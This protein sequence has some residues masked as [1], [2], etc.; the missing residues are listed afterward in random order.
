MAV[1]RTP[2]F[3]HGICEQCLVGE[4]I[5]RVPEGR[6]CRRCKEL[7][8]PALAFA[9]FLGQQEK[10]FQRTERVVFFG[11][12]G[13][14][15]KSVCIQAKFGQQLDSEHKRWK[16]N[17]NH[18]SKAW[19]VYFRRTSPD[20][21]QA[22]QRSFEFFPVIDPS[23]KFNENKHL[24]TLPSCGGAVFEYAQME[25]VNDRYKYKSREWSYIGVDEGSEFEEVMIE[26]AETRLRTADPYL[27]PYLQ[28]VVGSNPDGPHML[29][30][31]DRFIEP[32][33]PETVMSVETKLRDGRMIEYRQVYIP[34]RLDDNP[35][36]MESGTYEASLMNKRPEIRR[37]ILEGDW[38]I[39]AGAFLGSIWDESMHVVEDHDIPPGA[40]IFRAG[41]WGINNP[42]SIGWWY[43]DADGGMTMFDH[44][45][46]VGLTVDKVCEK[47]KVIEARWGL[48]DEETNTSGLNFARNP[49]DSACF[50]TGQGLIG[51]RTIAKDFLSLGFRWKP[52]RKGPGSRLQG[53]SQIIS[54]MT[55]I[56]PAAFDGAEDP[57][58]RAR[59]MI[60]F[61]RRCAS[62]RKTL[63][64]LMADP[65]NADDVD[66]SGDDHDWDQTMYASL[67]NPVSLRTDQPD[68][69]D[70]EGSGSAP[71]AAR[72][73]TSMGSAPWTR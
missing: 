46:T 35:I 11:G 38:Y 5:F 58:E 42:S 4:A 26:Y 73:T 72:S 53:A 70:D 57:T 47:M 7:R 65:T 44:L 25:H 50:G 8:R 36:L 30:L 22:V 27:E 59:P 64:T 43:V 28:L 32:A 54:R 10:F 23:A 52:A 48:W 1:A 12:A 9:P 68:D 19:G 17:K 41:D 60:R 51:A 62:P 2:L 33:P 45:R 3:K 18:H 67:E 15:G 69:D 31:R 29:W 6:W 24:W 34:S 39:A 55:K 66:T 37:A 49:L 20:F 16:L 14:G 13:G 71:L 61:M 63:P 56:I 40:T 21:K